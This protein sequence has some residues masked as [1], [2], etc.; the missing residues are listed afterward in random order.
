MTT[1][2]KS[3]D[4]SQLIETVLR[5]EQSLLLR[6]FDGMDH[7]T[8][9]KMSFDERKQEKKKSFG[10]GVSKGNNFKNEFRKGS[11]FRS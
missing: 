4:F 5:V 8:K 3:K 2:S 11:L 1:T 10:L 6:K 9:P 7:Q